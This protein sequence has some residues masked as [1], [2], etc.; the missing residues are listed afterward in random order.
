MTQIHEKKVSASAV[1]R[2]MAALCLADHI[3][4][5]ADDIRAM[6]NLMGLDMEGD[7]GIEEL[8]QCI[9]DHLP[10]PDRSF[11]TLTREEV[12]HGE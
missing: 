5:M 3:G 6:C 12:F 2:F 11:H 9:V 1:M 7:D 4:D 8:R 10:E